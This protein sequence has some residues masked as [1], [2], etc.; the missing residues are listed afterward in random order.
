MPHVDLVMQESNMFRMA[1]RNTVYGWR[2]MPDDVSYYM[3]RSD[4]GDCVHTYPI[5]YVEPLLDA[6]G[7]LWGA[8]LYGPVKHVMTNTPLRAWYLTRDKAMRDVEKALAP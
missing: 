1:D 8:W 6:P 4:Y 5:G 3:D 2:D 7:G